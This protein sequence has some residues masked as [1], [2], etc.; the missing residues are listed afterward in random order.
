MS[1][2][3]SEKDPN[4]PA[5]TSFEYDAMIGTWDMLGTL[6]SGTAAMRR[7]GPDYLPQHAAESDPNY[8][9][10]V[11]VNILFNA[12]ELTLEHFVG[13][14]FSDPVRLNEDVPDDI[15]KHTVNIDLQ[16]N[17]LT[18]FCREWFRE[19][20]AK[21]F[22]HVLVDMPAMREEERVDRTR[23]DDTAEGRRPYWQLIRPENL[24]FGESTIM[25]DPVTGELREHYTHVRLHEEVTERVGFAQ[26]IKH[27]IRVL[28]PGFFQVWELVKVKGRKAQWVIIESGFTGIDFV[29]LVTFYASRED[30]LIAKPP[31]EDLGHM[32]IRHWQSMSDQINIL[33]VVRFPMLAVAGVTDQAGSAMQ[34]GPRQLLA[35]KDAN[36]RFYYV[37]HQGQ[38]IEAGWKELANLEE[39]MQAYGATFLKKDP[40]HIT[41]TGRA[42]DSAEAVTPLQD[43]T[44]RFIDSVNTC[45]SYHGFW[46]DE[47][48]G[49]TVEITTDFGPEEVTK[50]D[51]SLL[52][53]M[54]ASRDISRVAFLEEVQRRGTLAEDYDQE[55]DLAQIVL[56]DKILKPFQPQVPGTFDV[57][58]PDGDGIPGITKP[59]AAKKPE[60]K[61]PGGRKEM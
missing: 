33:T 50:E 52:E 3:N 53:K 5:T 7:A 46:L 60:A 58:D 27:R 55:A 31:L 49:G 18:A 19:S 14:P 41:A 10:R 44:V 38:S 61:E 23:A 17:D 28:E 13:R 39:A 56:E 32:N 35:T 12:F 30:Y 51:A 26:V 29:P 54:R 25:E 59:G 6:L 20:L 43:L 9:E 57:K 11:M 37:E 45:M 15:A 22:C 34:I 47:E 48:T 40:G 36:G 2:F 4:S 21:G 42:L 1:I 24:I 8:R 16:G